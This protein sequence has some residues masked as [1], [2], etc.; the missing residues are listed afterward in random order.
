MSIVAGESTSIDDGEPS[1]ASPQASAPLPRAAGEGQ[2]G[3]KAPRRALYVA[4]ERLSMLLA[5]FPDAVLDPEIESPHAKSYS[6]DEAL[7][8]IVRGRLEALGPT[9]ARSIAN[10]LGVPSEDVDA[11]LIALEAEGTAMRGTFESV[12]LVAQGSQT[13]NDVQWC[14]RRLLARIHRYTVKRLRAEIEPVQSRD[15]LRFLFDWQRVTPTA[16]M[17]GP[18]AVASVLAQLEGFDAPASAWESELLPLRIGEYDPAWLD[19]Q[20]LAGR[21]VW[22][23]LAPRA[24][25]GER[26]AAPV[27]STPIALLARRNVKW[28]SSFVADP[29][30]VPLTPKA[31][32]IAEF[33]QTHGA[34]FFDE[35]VDQ[36]GLLPVQVEEALAELVAKGLVN[37][38]SFGGLRALLLPAD[39]RRTHA[40]HARR[41]RR[42]AI[43]GMQDA[44]RWAMVRKGARAA[45][46]DQPT[47]E[48]ERTASSNNRLQPTAHRLSSDPEAIEHLCRT[49]LSRWGVV[50]WKVLEREADWLPPWRELLMCLRRLEA[51]GEIRGGRFI[52]GFSGEQFALPEAIGP[53]R[54][55]RRKPLNNEYLSISAADPLNL[56]GIIT[57]GARLPA[58]TGNRVLYRDGLPIALYAGGEVRFVQEIEPEEQWRA[59]NALL[60]SQ[61]LSELKDLASK[62]D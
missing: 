19:E 27:R 39:R 14:N 50:F 29:A 20:C 53:L 41:K 51:R 18:D 42:V 47:E 6:R 58:L 33:I 32:R 54:E 43:F 4:A 49:L 21:I 45:V 31:Q 57:P 40:P 28:W 23:R 10:T 5:V 9:T 17:Q 11:A 8:E 62:P 61:A 22:T 16:R 25:D 48:H 44:G 36:A 15:F 7:V 12:P 30:N 1:V 3:G 13:V 2:G 56:V 37:S 26:G 34:S 46:T 52:A 59:Q 24:G 35:I 60:R 38:D 55:A